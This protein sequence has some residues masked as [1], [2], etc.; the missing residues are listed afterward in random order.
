MHCKRL[1]AAYSTYNN[2]VPALGL[3]VTLQLESEE[4]FDFARE[5]D[6]TLVLYVV[7][8]SGE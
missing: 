4:V 1:A 3:L 2:N 8:R 5:Q 6:V 7:F